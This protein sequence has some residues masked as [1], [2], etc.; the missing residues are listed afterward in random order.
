M[1]VVVVSLTGI[2]SFIIPSY[3]MRLATRLLYYPFIGMAWIF[4]LIGLLLA[5]L[6][7]LTHLGRMNTMG[8][9]Y[10]YS[11]LSGDTIKDTFF[12]GPLRSLKK[13][14]KESLSEDE[15]RIGDPKG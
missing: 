15:T 11:A 14:P 6:L 4:G 7:M 10:F 1:M 12:R 13:R 8:I 9:P 5:F 3:E 2:A